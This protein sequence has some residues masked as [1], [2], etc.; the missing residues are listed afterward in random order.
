MVIH[1]CCHTKKRIANGLG[2]D[3]KTN[4]EVVALEQVK[5]TGV[6]HGYGSYNGVFTSHCAKQTSPQ[7]VLWPDTDT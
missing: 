5:W 1:S 3:Q 4:Y 7:S 6:I 2:D